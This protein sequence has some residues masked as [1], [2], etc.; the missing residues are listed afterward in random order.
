MNSQPLCRLHLNA[1]LRAGLNLGVVNITHVGAQRREVAAGVKAAGVG[2]QVRAFGRVR[3]RVRLEKGGRGRCV[4]ALGAEEAA[5]LDRSVFHGHVLRQ[6]AGSDVALG[7]VR[8]RVGWLGAVFPLLVH[9]QQGARGVSPIALAALE[10]HALLARQMRLG[11]LGQSFV[12]L[13][14]SAAFGAWDTRR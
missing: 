6:R 1:A 5:S 7:A 3:G 9:P 8:A 14:T 2:A 13:E 10:K 11:V 4:A 12:V